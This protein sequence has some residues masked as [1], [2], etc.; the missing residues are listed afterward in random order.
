MLI[1]HEQSSNGLG[2]A[3]FNLFY[4]ENYKVSCG[5]WGY[6]TF[7]DEIQ[8][9]VATGSFVIHLQKGIYDDFTFDF[10]WTATKT[11]LVSSG[12]WERGNP[13]PTSTLS[14]PADDAQFDCGD[15]AYITGNDVSLNPDEDD[16][17]KGSVTLY[18]PIFDL[19]T[20]TNPHVNYTRWFYNFHGP[21]PPPDD[22]L[23]IRLSNGIETVLI[24]SQASEDISFYQ[25]I[26]QSIRILDF[27]QP[28]ANMQLIVTVSD[29]DPA[30]NITEAGIDFFHVTETSILGT[31]EASS[32]V[33]SIYPVPTSGTVTIFQTEI[34]K[35]WSVYS[36][37]GKL[38]QLIEKETNNIEIDLSK[39]N[40]GTYLIKS[41]QEIYRVIKD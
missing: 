8:I 11:A 3:N 14:A 40:S 1:S 9:D 5:K 29:E 17:D 32:K 4:A 27:M 12:E 23:E 39:L 38:F 41:D 28:T 2:E 16:V 31:L 21:L 26:P 30:V 19:T 36:I 13:N 6:V 37:E 33:N 22:T 7:C 34:S 24:D 10:G 18:S 35:F 15:F 20:Y 25:W